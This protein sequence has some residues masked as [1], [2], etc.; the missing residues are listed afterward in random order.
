MDG[1][2]N[3]DV[4][5]NGAV[6]IGLRENKGVARVGTLQLG[7]RDNRLYLSLELDGFNQSSGGRGPGPND[8]VIL[9][10]S[11]DGDSTHDWRIHIN[12]F[13]RADTGTGLRVYDSD[14]PRVAYV[15]RDSNHWTE[16]KSGQCAPTDAGKYANCKKNLDIGTIKV[17][18]NDA[19]WGLEMQLPYHS[20]PSRAGN[21]DSIYVPATGEFRL[22]ANVVSTNDL[23]GSF[24]QDPWPHSS[25]LLKPS[26]FPYGI[27]YNTPPKDKDGKRV[28]GT[29]SLTTRSICKG[30][31]IVAAGV[32]NTPTE[33]ATLGSASTPVQPSSDTA[34]IYYN[35]VPLSNLRIRDAQTCANLADNALWS[36]SKTDPTGVYSPANYFVAKVQK[37]DSDTPAKQVSAKFYIAPWGI[38][39]TGDWHKIGELYDP[40]PGGGVLDSEQA[41]AV[42]A[43][44]GTTELKAAWYLSY[45]QSCAYLLSNPTTVGGK[46]AGHHCVQAELQSADPNTVILRKSVQ[47][48]HDI[49]SASTVGREAVINLRG[50]G[51][52]PR[53]LKGKSRK[54]HEVLLTVDWTVR[55]YVRRGDEYY[56]DPSPVRLRRYVRRGGDYYA[57]YAAKS[58]NQAH[59]ALETIPPIS[60]Q[61]LAYSKIHVHSVPKGIKQAMTIITRG[62]RRTGH[63]LDVEGK[64][65][66]EMEYLGGYG[67]EAG[68]YQA[69]SQWG[70]KL[71]G[72][73][74]AKATVATP[75]DTYLL[76][77]PPGKGLVKVVTQV[78]AR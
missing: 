32:R 45:K 36:G 69:A 37:S 77:I 58:L 23:A 35:T 71:Q 27:E 52:P 2:P 22:Y 70:V 62:Y 54:A 67:L 11:T 34:G 7:H 68:H 28:W 73:R 26:S 13:E 72:K 15:W 43:A 29:A 33:N 78:T 18:R 59:G 48:N 30:V 10:L 16:T 57:P 74:I 64:R 39:G 49:V 12:P 21:N 56:A 19:R 40:N 5:W 25:Q 14:E 51:K 31:S 8:T 17:S 61:F 44:P 63:L 65:Y 50:Y 47:F 42:S 6:Q 66:E 4:G 1:N 60:P 24:V 76:S 53:D 3:N 46:P 55:E 20:D 9:A 75:K 41:E 38:P